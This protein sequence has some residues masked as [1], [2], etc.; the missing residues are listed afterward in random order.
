[1]H[2]RMWSAIVGS[3]LLVT[4]AFQ[5]STTVP[6]QAMAE[7]AMIEGFYVFTDAKPVAPH[8]VLGEVEISFV[9]DTQYQSIRNSLIL[10]ARKK[11]PQANG[12]IFEFNKRGIDK[13]QVIQ[14][15]E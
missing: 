9:A 7:V 10:K 13:C 15:D 11:Y 12:L 1:M 14:F 8:Q 5:S 4:M 6:A 3:I 2:H